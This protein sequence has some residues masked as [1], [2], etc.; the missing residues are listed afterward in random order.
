VQQLLELV[1]A[2]TGWG[3]H[4]AAS[5]PSWAATPDGLVA[6][7]RDV[8]P[9]ELSPWTIRLARRTAAL[10]E[11]QPLLPARGAQ[12]QLP[13]G[14]AAE[15]LPRPA[16][17]ALPPPAAEA[18][19]PP[20][21]EELPPPA[22]EELPRPAAEEP[23][24]VEPP[25]TRGRAVG[26]LLNSKQAPRI[27]LVAIPFGCI[28]LGAAVGAIDAGLDVRDFILGAIA[29]FAAATAATIGAGRT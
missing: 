9:T 22:T 23:P 1:L 14:P 15:A 16:P 6:E 8:L 27:R 7:L 21:A 25:V 19:P 5:I 2:Q 26:S 17:E 10:R 11:P 24:A 12:A 13:A 29:G 20:A 18:L 28:V 3:V 4:G